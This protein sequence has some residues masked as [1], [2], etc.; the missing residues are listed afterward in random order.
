MAFL[1]AQ[2]QESSVPRNDREG[3]ARRAILE[4][5]DRIDPARIPLVV[6][7][8]GTLLRTNSLPESLMTLARKQPLKLLS[9]P[10]WC[11]GGRAQLDRRLAQ[12][13]IPDVRTLPYRADVLVYLRAQKQRGRRL[14]LSTGAYE[15]LGH[16]VARELGLFDSVIAS[17]GAGD[18]GSRRKG[19]RL[20]AEFGIGG[21][22]YLGYSRRDLPVWRNARH[23]L[24]VSASRGLP[25]DVAAVVPVEQVFM[26]RRAGPQD[27][28]QALRVH[29]WI[30]NV[31]VFV[32]LVAAHRS[33]EPALMLSALRAFAAFS[34]CAAGV[35]LL[36]DMLDLADD[37]RHPRKRERKLAAGQIPLAHS[38]LL[39]PLL[40]A[41]A[42]LIGAQLPRGFGFTLSAYL[43]LMFGY[44]FG[45][46]NVPVLD[47]LMLSSGYTLRVAA[48]AAAI[49]VVS[50]TWLLAFSILI[51]LSLALLKRYAELVSLRNAPAHLR[52]ARG[53]VAG[54][55]RLLVAEGVASGYLAAL[56]L[57]LYAN[58]DLARRAYTHCELLWIVALLLLAWISHAWLV[59][60]RGRIHH[61]LVVF[62][63]QDWVSLALICAVS[64]VAVLAL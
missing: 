62:A 64:A 55:E 47:V 35:Y 37:R 46:K 28:L 24:V 49:N 61:D 1:T 13:A 8:D 36:N 43:V 7:L 9:V 14:V 60:A 45:L 3:P 5:G 2:L 38:L 32:P 51:F 23:A 31:L 39:L 16:E 63:F 27:Y 6:D 40:L 44:C 22:D 48:G 29:H 42:F 54:D 4:A 19:E 11:I 58:T 26:H 18:L 12:A 53:Y 41:G 20:V 57:V 30:K 52:R 56:V 59:A 25:R 50:P 10:L 21:F 15:R 34:L 33:F 17:T